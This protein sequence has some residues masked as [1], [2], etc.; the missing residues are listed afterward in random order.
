MNKALVV[1]RLTRDPELR[2]TQDGLAIV[3]F[4]VAV[5]EPMNRD[6]ERETN[7]I[8]C[9]SFGRQAENISK[10]CRKGSM[11]SVEGRIRTRSYDA[12]DG[13]K[14]YVTEVYCDRVN[15]LSSK[16]ETTGQASTN[17]SNYSSN[18]Y[19]N[20]SMPSDMELAKG[21]EAPMNSVDLS[22]DPFKSFG[23]EITLS[24]D[25]LPF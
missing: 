11:V 1:G 17:P 4:S 3:R 21:A 12:Q 23:E 20:T 24:S 22:E 14:R 9:T 18:S 7:Y 19:N 25:D 5:S 16:S 10:Y 15:F 8:N 2:T 13:T 6:G